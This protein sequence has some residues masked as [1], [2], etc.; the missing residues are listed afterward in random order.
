[1]QITVGVAEKNVFQ[2]ELALLALALEK[3]RF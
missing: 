1:M 3:K 2:E